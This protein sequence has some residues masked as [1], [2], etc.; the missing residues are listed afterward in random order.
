MPGAGTWYDCIRRMKQARSTTTANDVPETPTSGYNATTTQAFM[1]I[2]HAV[3]HAYAA[4]IPVGSADAFC[5]AHPQ[6]LQKQILRLFY[7]PEQRMR[8][9]AKT[10]FVEPDL[11]PLPEVRRA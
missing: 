4:A 3:M 6:L 10:S 9:D 2:I 8:P 11:A 1:R 5:E 7:S